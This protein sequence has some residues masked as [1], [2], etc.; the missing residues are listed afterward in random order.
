[1][2]ISGQRARLL[3]CYI[4][5]RNQFAGSAEDR[6]RRLLEKIAE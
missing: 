4:T 3:A 6:E 1:M 5:D 2:R